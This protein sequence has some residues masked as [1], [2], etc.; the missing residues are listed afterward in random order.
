MRVGRPKSSEGS[1]CCPTPAIVR[2]VRE[3]PKATAK[4]NSRNNAVEKTDDGGL[5]KWCV[6]CGAPFDTVNEARKLCYACYCKVLKL[7]PQEGLFKSV[8]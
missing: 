2:A 3:I 4:K 5:K 1:C 8:Y 6:M 7:K